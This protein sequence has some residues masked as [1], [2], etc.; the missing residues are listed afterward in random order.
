MKSLWLF[1]SFFL[2]ATILNG[3]YKKAYRL[4]DQNGRDVQWNQWID[5]LSR[6]D[7]VLFGELHNNPIAHWL[8]FE[9]VK[10]LYQKKGKQ[11]VVGAEM[12]ERD[13]QLLIDEYLSGLIKQK[14]FEE[15]AKLWNNYQTD[16]K[17]ILEFAKEKGI[18]FVATNVPRRY[19]ALVH[20]KGLAA[21]DILSADAKLHI[22]PLPIEFDSTLGC[23]KNM[24]NMGS[25]KTGITFAQAQ[26]VKDATMAHFILKNW[27]P[28]ITFF[29]INGAYHSDNFEGIVWYLKRKQPNLKIVTL[30]TVEMEEIENISFKELPRA[31][32]YLIVPTSMTKT[33]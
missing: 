30:T 24:L 32:F 5:D 27:N 14:N 6:Q 15:E 26:A 7:I 21:L 4:V 13:D 3:Q 22:A 10:A 19:A 1:F 11:L 31:N 12:F 2:L 9:L 29:H 20:S 8:E 25:H 18:L 17:P 28:G 33:Y 23:Y 16:Y